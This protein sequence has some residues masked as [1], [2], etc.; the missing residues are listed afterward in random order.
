MREEENK[1]KTYRTNLCAYHAPFYLSFFFSLSLFLSFFL[2]FFLSLY[3][4]LSLSLSRNASLTQK[5]IVVIT[6]I[7][8]SFL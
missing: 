3:L 2:S 7:A 1:K 6:L 8:H 4:S 5:E